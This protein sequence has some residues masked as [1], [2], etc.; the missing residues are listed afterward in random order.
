VG[1]MTLEGNLSLQLLSRP[2]QSFNKHHGNG[3]DNSNDQADQEG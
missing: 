3:N 2:L 1:P